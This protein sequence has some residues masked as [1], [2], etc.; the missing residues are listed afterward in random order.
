MGTPL[1]IIVTC[2]SRKTIKPHPDL[3]VGAFADRNEKANDWIAAVE[4]V[5]QSVKLD[6]KIMPLDL[7]AGEH[8]KIAK[9]LPLQIKNSRHWESDLWV[10]SAGYGLLHEKA[11]I[12]SYAAAFSNGKADSI[13]PSLDTDSKAFRTEWW[14]KLMKLSSG[15]ESKPK[16]LEELGR[17]D[18]S[19]KFLIACSQPYLQAISD[20]LKLIPNFAQRVFIVST[21]ISD[22]E[23]ESCRIK[24]Q[25]NGKS[26]A[27][28]KSFSYGQLGA[29]THGGLF[30]GSMMSLNVQIGED[31]LR[32]IDKH[33]FE[34]EKL[35]RYFTK[36]LEETGQ[37]PKKNMR[38]RPA[39]DFEVIED[40]RKYIEITTVIGEV[41]ESLRVADVNSASKLK[42]LKILMSESIEFQRKAD[43]SKLL[44][45][46][47]EL[48]KKLFTEGGETHSLVLAAL[49]QFLRTIYQI[50]ETPSASGALKWYRTVLFK[51]KEE[52]AFRKLYK[53]C[54]H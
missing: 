41:R 25:S 10:L 50:N 6:E 4:K 54:V 20:D 32:N 40:I 23:L 19:S 26:Y 45:T 31:L 2:T 46:L 37:R 9:E 8:W 43:Q 48:E 3:R 52:K 17:K 38:K 1:N 33:Q 22:P 29:Q 35:N 18:E 53:E 42:A 34:R 47:G 5:N 15:K 44:S 21:P 12:V 28:L 13:S 49:D 30:S 27:D 24:S 11:K 16:S 14:G 39:D 51:Q 36:R 7:Y